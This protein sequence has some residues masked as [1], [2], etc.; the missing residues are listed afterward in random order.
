MGKTAEMMKLDFPLQFII[1]PW[2]NSS[3]RYI[4]KSRCMH[5][6]QT[7]ESTSKGRNGNIYDLNHMFT[8]LNEPPAVIVAT[9]DTCR[10]VIALYKKYTLNKKVVIYIDESQL[11]TYDDDFYDIYENKNSTVQFV[12]I[13]HTAMYQCETVNRRCP[14]VVDTVTPIC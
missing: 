2:S 3:M 14:N 9:H 4:K 10:K 8:D 12:L 7:G 5:H 1:T 11:F 6:V 13:C